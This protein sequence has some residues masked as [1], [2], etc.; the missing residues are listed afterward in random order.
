MAYTFYYDSF[1]VSTYNQRNRGQVYGVSTFAVELRN[2]NFELIKILTKKVKG[3]ISWQ[4]NRI[5][6]C[7]SCTILLSLSFEELKDYI[8]PDYEIR[9]FAVLDDTSA[10]LIYRGFVENYRPKVGTP[11]SAQIDVTGYVGQLKRVPVIRTYSNTEVSEIIKDILDQDVLPNTSIFYESADIQDSGY[12]ID[13]IEFDTMADEAIRTLARIAGNFEYG[14][15]RNLDFYFKR[16]D[17]TI[18]HF[19]RVKKD[20]RDFDEINDYSNIINRYIIKGKDSFSDT[21]NNTES[22]TLYGIR[23]KMISNSSIITTALS[24]RYGSMLLAESARIAR[25]ASINI[26]NK[27]SLFEN[28]IP[29]GKLAIIKEPVDALTKYGADTYGSFK[30]GGLISYDIESVNYSI[31][32]EKI[33]AKVQLGQP[34][35]DI[36]DQIEQM[37]FE[38]SQLRNI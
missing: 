24:Q 5:G 8:K 30:Y 36:S 37:N 14:V 25:R 18:Q 13:T 29:L 27:T 4:Y 26:V 3:E 21:V 9:I 38:I 31:G 7:G 34:R 32:S 6:G 28:T 22:Q 20:V 16:K 33:S 17:T 1:I 10:E 19:A 23:A 15:D 2:T 35:P 11:D 12:V